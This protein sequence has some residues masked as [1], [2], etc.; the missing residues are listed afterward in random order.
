MPQKKPKYRSK[1]EQA[2]CEAIPSDCGYEYEP[3]KIKYVIPEKKANYIPDVVLDNGIIVEMKGWFK[4]TDRKKHELIRIS[5]PELD[6]RFL[7]QA[8][9][10]I[11]RKS[12]MR[13][14]DWC[15]K[16]GFKY[17]I[18]KEIPSEWFEEKP[19]GVQP[20]GDTR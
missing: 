8:N 7:F 18:G 17:A 10:K 13:Y 15:D 6:I 5:N 11:H 12:E 20:S 4:P 1:F 19:K 14:A 9:S 16:H 2:V 3:Y